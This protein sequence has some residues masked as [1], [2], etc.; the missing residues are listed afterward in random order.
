MNNN[1]V[2]SSWTC[3]KYCNNTASIYNKVQILQLILWLSDNIRRQSPR[4]SR[5]PAEEVPVQDANVM[6][7]QQQKGDL[8]LDLD[9][10]LWEAVMTASLP[11]AHHVS[12]PT[13]L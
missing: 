6:R 11:T 3:T 8:D 1:K 2:R 5:Q 10:V 13:T 7:V 4:R 12:L 9:D